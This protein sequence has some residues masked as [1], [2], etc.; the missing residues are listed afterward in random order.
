M[1]LYDSNK[2]GKKAIIRKNV[3]Y[4]PNKKDPWFDKIVQ[5]DGSA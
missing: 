1:S 3:V 5:I 2:S 4:L